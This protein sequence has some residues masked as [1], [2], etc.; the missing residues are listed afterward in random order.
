MQASKRLPENADFCRRTARFF[1][2][3]VSEWYYRF[4]RLQEAISRRSF[5]SKCARRRES[6]PDQRLLRAPV[7][8]DGSTVERPDEKQEALNEAIE[9]VE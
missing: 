1:L 7:R 4:A 3:A 2:T 9:K 8:N 5:F 6:K